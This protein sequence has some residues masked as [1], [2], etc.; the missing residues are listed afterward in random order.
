MLIVNTS[1]VIYPLQNCGLN[2]YK[3]HCLGFNNIGYGK[4]M[5]SA[6]DDVIESCFMMVDRKFNFAT[7][8]KQYFDELTSNIFV[9]NSEFREGRCLINCKIFV[10]SEIQKRLFESEKY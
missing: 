7:A 4:T 3:V 2:N 5:E 10:I 6:I 9:K 1:L 8:S